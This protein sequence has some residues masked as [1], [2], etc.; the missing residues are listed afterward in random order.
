METLALILQ[1]IRE[2]G[3]WGAER[4]RGEL[5]KLGIKVSKRTV[6]RSMRR[7]RRPRPHG[8]SWRTFLRNHASHIWACDFIQTYDLFFRAIFVFVIIEH[9]SRRVVH[10]GVTRTPSDRWVAQQLREATPF[11]DTPKYLIRENDANTVVGFLAL[12]R[13]VELKNCVFR[14]ILR[15]A[16]L[17][18]NAS[19]DRSAGN[20]WIISSL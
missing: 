17:C 12:C 9:S 4:I 16:M 8:Q 5:L 11:G 6:Q 19:L 13:A 1:M 7:E 10:Y 20:V 2:N 3:L 15:I 18:V 14:I